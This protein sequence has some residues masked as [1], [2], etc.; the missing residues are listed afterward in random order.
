MSL[1]VVAYLTTKHV[2]YNMPA[3]VVYDDESWVYVPQ[4]YYLSPLDNQWHYLPHQTNVRLREAIARRTGHP[5]VLIHNPF[6][7]YVGDGFNPT[8]WEPA[9]ET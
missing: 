4:A 1:Y 7:R 8:R 6:G 2:F 5:V 9:M 3:S